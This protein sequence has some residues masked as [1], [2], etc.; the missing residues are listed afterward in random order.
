MARVE[1]P[2]LIMLY[3]S[4]LATVVFF[5]PTLYVWH[6]PT[7]GELASL[8]AVAVLGIVNQVCFIAACRVGEMTVVAPIDYTRL[9]FAGILGYGV[10][11][12]VAGCLR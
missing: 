7:P 4:L 8:G 2:E 11:G 10:F 3:F 1:P 9:L 5:L 12:E 6:N